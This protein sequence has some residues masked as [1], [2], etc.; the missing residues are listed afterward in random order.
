MGELAGREVRE[1]DVD[2]AVA[3]RGEV[4]ESGVAGGENGGVGGEVVGFV[5]SYY[6]LSGGCRNAGCGGGKGGGVG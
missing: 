5:D 1:V 6:F 2:Y 4:C 3:C